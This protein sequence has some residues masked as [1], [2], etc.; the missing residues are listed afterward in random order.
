LPWPMQ[1]NPRSGSACNLRVLF[2]KSISTCDV[3]HHGDLKL[4][5]SLPLDAGE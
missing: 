3:D 4:A 1:C 2:E 5:D